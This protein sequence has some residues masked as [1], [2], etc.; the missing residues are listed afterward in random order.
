MSSMIVRISE[1]AHSTLKRLAEAGRIPMQAVLDEAVE[2]Y[3]RRH[4]LDRVN[5][6]YGRLRKNR[7]AWGDLKRE[8]EAWDTTLADG[9]AVTGNTPKVVTPVRRRAAPATGAGR[10]IR[11]A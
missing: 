4:F 9:L 1:D 7:K 8:R 5:V 3:R 10:R 11:R 6:A 2:L